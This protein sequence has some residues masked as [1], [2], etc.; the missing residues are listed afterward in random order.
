[1]CSFQTFAE[2]LLKGATSRVSPLDGLRPEAGFRVPAANLQDFDSTNCP[3][4]VREVYEVSCGPTSP[5]VITDSSCTRMHAL[6]SPAGCGVA[7]SGN[8]CDSL[9]VPTPSAP[10]LA[11]QE[12][13]LVVRCRWLA[14]AALVR[15]FPCAI[16]GL[17]GISFEADV[18]NTFYSS[19]LCFCRLL[20]RLS[21]SASKPFTM[22]KLFVCECV[23]HEK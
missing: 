13:E 12:D 5:D 6:T 11:Y 22:A 10:Q 7:L 4:G 15:T 9:P 21:L 3:A 8:S 17:R 14:M 20:V 1:M 2:L 23:I 18:E 19:I 16:L